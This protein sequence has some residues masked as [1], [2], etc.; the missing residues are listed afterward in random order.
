MT[1]MFIRWTGDVRS[2]LSSLL[3]AMMMLLNFV[4]YIISPELSQYLN[5]VVML[6]GVLCYIIAFDGLLSWTN[7]LIISMCFLAYVIIQIW[8]F[9]M[10]NVSYSLS[11]ISNILLA[12]VII[13]KKIFVNPLIWTYSA[14]TSYIFYKVIILGLDPNTIFAHTS[15]NMIS[16]IAIMY[17]VLIYLIMFLKETKVT[18]LPAL[19]ALLLSIIAIGR[20]GV[21]C[22]LLLLIVVYIYNYIYAKESKKKWYILGICVFIL[23]LIYFAKD[24]LSAGEIEFIS[25]WQVYGVSDPARAQLLNRYIEN[26]DFYTFMKGYDITSD[27][28][29]NSWNNNPHNSWIYLHYHLGIWGVVLIGLCFISGVKLFI[30][31][32]LFLLFLLLIIILRASTDSVIFFSNYDFIIYSFIILTFKIRHSFLDNKVGLYREQANFRA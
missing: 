29:Y 2:V 3:L 16:T 26:I 32:Q 25:R 13:E 22:A 21:V 30:K 28:I 27:I 23:S 8:N 12:C 7:L 15:R 11:I 14:I 9:K 19:I 31:K 6:C 17:G 24:A 10:G 20:T 4:S 18:I 5:Y 1:Y